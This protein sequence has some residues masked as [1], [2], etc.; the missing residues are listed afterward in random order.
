MSS[1]I[2]VEES[3]QIARPPAEVWDAIADYAFDLEWR[4]GLRE[5]TPDP[6]GPLPARGSTRWSGPR[7]ATTSQTR[8]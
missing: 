1:T 7:D 5:M 6:P 8:R 2:R 3:V 4:K